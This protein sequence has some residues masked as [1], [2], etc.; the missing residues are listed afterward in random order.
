VLTAWF[1]WCGYREARGQGA[2][3]LSDGRCLPHLVHSAAMLYMFAAPAVGA[4]AGGGPGM[5][6]M[7]GV[8]GPT[9]QTLRLPAVALAFAVWLCAYVVLDLDRLS[10]PAWHAR[11]SYFARVPP[12]PAGAALAGASATEATASVAAPAGGVAQRPV[13]GTSPEPGSAVTGSGPGTSPAFLLSPRLA[14]VCRIAMGVT[15]AFMLVIMI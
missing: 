2:R 1:A 6:G 12:A 14:A 9:M 8:S 15:M 10:G 3:V 7:G 5:S 13:A 4:A 11:G